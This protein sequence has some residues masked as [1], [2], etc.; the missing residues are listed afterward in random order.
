M[1]LEVRASLKQG[2]GW[3]GGAETP[4]QAS[5]SQLYLEHLWGKPRGSE[6]SSVKIALLTDH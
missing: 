2:N 3:R 6:E 4:P 5:I 1:L